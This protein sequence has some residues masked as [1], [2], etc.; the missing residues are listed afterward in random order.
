M[1]YAI[2]ALVVLIPH[3]RE[4]LV[5]THAT[6]EPFR[7]LEPPHVIRSALLD[8]F[9]MRQAVAVALKELFFMP[10]YQF[11]LLVLSDI[12]PPRLGCQL[13]LLALWELMRILLG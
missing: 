2:L 1:G 9:Q 13:A 12:L 8:T 7:L 3:H 5:A 11:A 4:V 6:R 10:L